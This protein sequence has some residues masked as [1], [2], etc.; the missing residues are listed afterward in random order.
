MRAAPPNEGG[1]AV[2]WSEGGDYAQ[3]SCRIAQTSF[4]IF[5]TY[6]I[7]S[8]SNQQRYMRTFSTRVRDPQPIAELRCGT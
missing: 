2:R 6:R 1:A 4:Q 5:V 7:R 3:P 8:P